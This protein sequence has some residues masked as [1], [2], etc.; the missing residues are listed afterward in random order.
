MKAFSFMQIGGILFVTLTLLETSVCPAC[1]CTYN[2]HPIAKMDF[3]KK[4]LPPLHPNPICSPF[5]CLI[6][7]L[8]SA[9][10]LGW[11]FFFF[12]N[13]TDLGDRDDMRT[14]RDSRALREKNRVED[15]EGQNVTQRGSFAERERRT[16]MQTGG[17][18]A[19]A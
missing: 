2:V 10:W 14:G 6:K 9:A 19:T 11:S 3:Q 15:V 13:T 8:K 16:S 18:T 12:L 5:V 1:H 7:A 4:R 17:H